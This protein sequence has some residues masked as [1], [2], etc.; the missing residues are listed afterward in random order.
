MKHL[1]TI[2]ILSL[3]AMVL[4]GCYDC[5]PPAGPAYSREQLGA[6]RSRG[7]SACA[8]IVPILFVFPVVGFMVLTGGPRCRVAGAFL[9]LGLL[10]WTIYAFV[11]FGE[12][13]QAAEALG[14]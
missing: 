12:Y 10:T 7:D 13:A 3:V 2:L 8:A 5:H 9:F 11:R 14:V 1:P 6:M 4:A